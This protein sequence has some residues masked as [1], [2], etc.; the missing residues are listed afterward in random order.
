MKKLLILLAF[1]GLT[2]VVVHAEANLQ[3]ALNQAITQA[4]A[5]AEL[6][7]RK[8]TLK[9]Y[10][11][12][13]PSYAEQGFAVLMGF[14]KNGT[15]MILMATRDLTNDIDMLG[16]DYVRGKVIKGPIVPDGDGRLDYRFVHGPNL[17]KIELSVKLKGQNLEKAKKLPLLSEAKAVALAQT[18]QGQVD[19]EAAEYMKKVK[20]VK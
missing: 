14:N 1:V 18:I 5:N 4:N 7:A 17:I 19:R 20:R 10:D 11:G 2:A 12:N 13:N 15:K 16:V 3:E 6:Q 8:V 9:A